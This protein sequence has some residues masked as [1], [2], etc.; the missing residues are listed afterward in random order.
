MIIS[1]AF[2]SLF[3]CFKCLFS[4][5]AIKHYKDLAP[6]KPMAV[7]G[8]GILVAVSFV[9]FTGGAKLVVMTVR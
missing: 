3:H 6:I 9:G 7:C 1:S 5:T 2:F 4:Y 8:K